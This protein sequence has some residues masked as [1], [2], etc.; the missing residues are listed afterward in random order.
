L[1]RFAAEDPGALFR[2]PA[3]SCHLRTLLGAKHYT[4]LR[5]SMALVSAEPADDAGAYTFTGSVRGLDLAAG[6]VRVHPDGRLWVAYLDD[7][8]APYFTNDRATRETPPAALEKWREPRSV[9]WAPETKAGD[10]F[11]GRV[12]KACPRKA[13]AAEEKA[14]IDRA[15]GRRCDA[16]SP[17]VD[18]AVVVGPAG[19]KTP[20]GG[21]TKLIPGDVVRVT[22]PVGEK[23]CAAFR[24]TGAQEAYG[25][26]PVERLSVLTPANPLLESLASS[27]G[28]P[29]SI[30]AGEWWNG[31]DAYLQV[32]APGGQGLVVEGEATAGAN[33]GLIQKQGFTVTGATAVTSPSQLPDEVVCAG[34][35]LHRFNNALYVTESAPCGGSG[36]SFE[37]AYFRHAERRTKKPVERLPER[38]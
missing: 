31:T 18:A 24:R 23:V 26:V 15:A 12:A 22:K 8:R 34:L 3:L 21:K 36:V 5:E 17:F 29:H 6:V 20:L 1:Q 33:V 9:A 14:E 38:Q 19:E 32:Y 4:T 37:G 28:K 30:W 10:G 13:I 27:P 25:T 11:A 16:K 2:D 35:K 7:K